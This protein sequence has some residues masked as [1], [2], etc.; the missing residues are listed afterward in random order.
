MRWW[1]V[2][3]A[4]T[5]VACGGTSTALATEGEVAFS[6]PCGDN[7][8]FVRVNDIRQEI[9][10]TPRTPRYDIKVVRIASVAGGV[11]VSFT[12]CEAPG[13]P[14][15]FEGSRQVAVHVAG[16]DLTLGV[17][18]PDV[19]TQPRTPIVTVNCPSGGGSSISWSADAITVDGD[20][21]TLKVLRAN[22]TGDAAALFAPG[23]V[24][25]DPV[26]HAAEN[27]YVTGGTFGDGPSESEQLPTGRDFA[28][29]HDPFAVS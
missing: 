15:G 14:D 11:A 8:A 9:P 17:Q 3:I 4:M 20:T 1:G 28:T 19:P 13:A 24:W 12:T 26:A 25:T 27:T 2:V 18:E 29:G 22:V 16:C 7:H 21:L 23:A 5:A 10:A 6:D